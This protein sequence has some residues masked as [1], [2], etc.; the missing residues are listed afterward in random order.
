MPGRSCSA[1]DLVIPAAAAAAADIQHTK[2]YKGTLNMKR[3]PL[4]NAV[5]DFSHDS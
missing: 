4:I 2:R 1:A 5:R 3:W